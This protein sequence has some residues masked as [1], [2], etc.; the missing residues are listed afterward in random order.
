MRKMKKYFL[1]VFRQSADC[2]GQEYNKKTVDSHRPEGGRRE[3][4]SDSHR[5]GGG[6]RELSGDSHRPGGGR[7]ELSGDSHRPEGGRRESSS[8][9]HCPEGGRRESDYKS[10]YLIHFSKKNGIRGIRIKKT[11]ATRI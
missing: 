9:S 3:S 6:R 7:R 2:S 1:K 5:P 10:Y 8:D 11:G 4:S